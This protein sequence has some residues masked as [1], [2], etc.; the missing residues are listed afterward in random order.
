M[1]KNSY[2]P[3]LLLIIA[4]DQETIRAGSRVRFENWKRALSGRFRDFARLDATGA[5]L[6]SLHAALRTLNADGLQIRIKAT[7]RAIVCV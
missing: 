2:R 4:S 1:E 5:N 3:T 6:H 7:R